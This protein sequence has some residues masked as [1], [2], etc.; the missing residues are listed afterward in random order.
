MKPL[1]SQDGAHGALPTL[2]AAVAAEAV[3]GCYYGPDG[4]GELKG[5][6]AAVPLAKGAMDQA[7]AKQLW[8]ESERLTNIEFGALSDVV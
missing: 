7:V 8:I 2:V 4:L 5:H 3:P 6:R 1:L